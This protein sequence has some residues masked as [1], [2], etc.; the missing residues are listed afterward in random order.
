[1]SALVI[2]YDPLPVFQ[3]FHRSTA[4]ERGLIGGYGSGKSRA[5]VA[6]AL[7]WGLQYPGSE[8]LITRKTI[9]S[10]KD[11]TEKDFIDQIPH[12]LW[13]ACR[14]ER[15]GGHIQNLYLPNGSL[16]HFRG[17]DDWRKIK[18]MNLTGIWIDEADEFEKET[19]EN[20]KSRLRQ[21]KP[22]GGAPGFIRYRTIVAASNPAGHNW[23]W[24]RFI[25]EPSSNRVGW[26]STSLDNPYNPVDY[27]EDMLNMPEPWVRRYVFCSFDDFEGSIY[28]E[29]GWETHVVK[30]YY[31]YDDPRGFFWMGMDPGT[32]HP[33]AGVW[34]YFDSRIN[35]LVIVAEYNQQGLS[36]DAHASAWGQIEAHG[37][38]NLSR[39]PGRMNV[40]RRIADP[41]IA[42]RDRGSM[43][44]LESQYLRL[45]YHFEHGPTKI[46]DRLPMLGQLIHQQ[47]IAVTE[48]CLQTFEQIQN[49]R[50]EDL[51]PQ[52]KERGV[53]AK[54]LKKNVDI[55][56][57]AQYLAS[58]WIPDPKPI[59]TPPVDPRE[60]TDVVYSNDSTA[61]LL[62]RGVVLT[63]DWKAQAADLVAGIDH[64]R[65]TPRDRRADTSRGVA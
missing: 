62:R 20:L 55:V 10:L 64:R 30:P 58:R 54:P 52:Q 28:P 40:R 33:T 14:V 15:G 42:T 37:T 60:T 44:A 47:R 4:L 11:T 12:E 45:G 50:Y 49:Y 63:D 51:T 57:A 16:Y 29:W 21:T 8:H 38:H 56:D 6:E 59:P 65:R 2:P 36:A 9:P 17:M 41:S 32:E 61:E 22:L 13:E 19:F 7:K 53:E 18:S 24:E 26:I 27:I 39:R 25:K 46:P 48:E 3:E 43:M 34:A 35:K 1:M 23:L 5:L 31:A